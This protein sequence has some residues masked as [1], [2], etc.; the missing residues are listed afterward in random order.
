MAIWVPLT[1]TEPLRRADAI[2]PGEPG[3]G[4][5]GGFGAAIIDLAG[6]HRGFAR[7]SADCLRTGGV[8][9]PVLP[10]RNADSALPHGGRQMRGRNPLGAENALDDAPAA[11]KGKGL[12][13]TFPRSRA[14]ILDERMT[15]MSA[16]DPARSRAV[17]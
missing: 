12:R 4:D 15:G 8:L 10:R 16:M 6:E 13:W 2:E 5:E 1:Q 7:P 14:N 3:D 11:T 9:R 17:D